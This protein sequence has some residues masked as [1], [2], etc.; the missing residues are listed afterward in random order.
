M[1]KRIPPFCMKCYRAAHD[2]FQHWALGA[3]VILIVAVAIAFWKSTEATQAVARA[4]KTNHGLI[5][6]IQTLREESAKAS[7]SSDIRLCRAINSITRRDLKS[8]I[9]SAEGSVPLLKKLGFTPQQL[10]DYLQAAKANERL[11]IKRRPLI[12]HGHCSEL[13]NP[14][15]SG[16]A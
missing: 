7:R 8:I 2:A 9:S 16:G 13:P 3:W 5:V 11:E 12:K 1:P 4:T 15:K 14:A 10:S 6:Q